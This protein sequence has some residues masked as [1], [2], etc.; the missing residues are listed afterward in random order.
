MANGTRALDN[1]PCQSSTI[2]Y[3]IGDLFISKLPWAIMSN[4]AM[5]EGIPMVR[6]CLGFDRINDLNPRRFIAM[7]DIEG[8]WKV[9][10]Y[11]GGDGSQKQATEFLKVLE[12]VSIKEVTAFGPVN[13]DHWHEENISPADLIKMLEPEEPI[14]AAKPEPLTDDTALLTA[15]TETTN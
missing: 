15:E 2:V 8:N 6:C 5:I 11:F 13:K 9:K 3:F 4:E 14:D 10:A 12:Q 1:G 7:F